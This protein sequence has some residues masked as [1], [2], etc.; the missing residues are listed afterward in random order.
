MLET[1]RKVYGH[2]AE[3][4]ERGLGPEARLWFHQEG[5]QP[6]MDRP[7]AWPEARFAGR[8]I[9]PD[10]SLGKAITRLL[11]PFSAD[12]L[13]ELERHAREPAAN[14]AWWMS[15]NCRHTLA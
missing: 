8:K 10:S 13:T 15:W 14:A 7:H 12:Y 5:S 9:E 11:R 6:R 1:L 4:R 2:H 3:A